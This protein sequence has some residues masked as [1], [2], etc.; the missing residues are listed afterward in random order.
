MSDKTPPTDENG[1]LIDPTGSENTNETTVAPPAPP[2]DTPPKKRRGR[3]PKNAASIGAEPVGDTG[4]DVRP[5]KAKTRRASYSSTDVDAM[6]KQL[7]GIHLILVQLTG[8]PELQITGDEGKALAQ[9]VVNIANQY[10]LEIDG[11]TGAAI[12][13]FATAAMIY[14]PRAFHYR[15][16]MSQGR[17]GTPQNVAEPA[18]N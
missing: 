12:Q 10:D 4:A 1:F 14:G 2:S 3:P 18:T 6:G 13:L 16:R 5:S 8:I 11:K 15:A 9:S 17:N 7:V